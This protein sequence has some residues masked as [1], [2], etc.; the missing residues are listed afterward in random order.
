[1]NWFYEHWIL[2]FLLAW[3]SIHSCYYIIMRMIRSVIVLF[4]GWPPEH[5]DADGDP[6][7]K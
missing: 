6:I 7:K 1:M 2:T 3:V 5:L 4:R